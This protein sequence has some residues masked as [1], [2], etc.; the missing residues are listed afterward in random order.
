MPY[1]GQ[2]EGHVDTPRPGVSQPMYQRILAALDG[3]AASEAVL[4]HA[5]AHARAFHTELILVRVVPPTPMGSTGSDASLATAAGAVPDV[6][7]A[8]LVATEDAAARSYL[9]TVAEPLIAS[10]IPVAVAVRAGPVAENIL[11]EADER[12]VGLIV[13]A[14]HG[15]V[16][17]ARMVLGS[18]ADEVV[19]HAPCAVLLLREAPASRPAE[20]GRVRSFREDADHAGP[21]APNVL[22]TRTVEVARIVGSVGRALELGPDFRLLDRRRRDERYERILAAM[23]R[24]DALPPVELYKL[25]YHYYVLDGNHR[26]AAARQLGQVDIDASVTEFVPVNSQEQQRLFSERRSFER[27]TGLTRVGANRPG[28]YSRLERLIRDYAAEVGMAEEVEDEATLKNAARGWYSHVF[29]PAAQRLRAARLGDTFPGERTADI[30]V[31]LADFRSREAEQGRGELPWDD[32]AQR[33]ILGVSPSRQ[34]VLGQLPGIRS[35]FR[36]SRARDEH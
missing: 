11:R 20:T 15:R 32:A 22:G 36:A 23:Q 9:D 4:R 21:L 14:T 12:A 18:V 28:T 27:A 19:R 30:F 33:F 5:V 8:S 25:G 29:Y 17:I 26:V 10:G 2:E 3:T 24:G 1:H 6:S 31:H 16:G 35:L 34:G 7:A 13:L